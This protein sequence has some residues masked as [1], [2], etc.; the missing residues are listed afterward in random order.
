MPHRSTGRGLLRRDQLA[1]PAGGALLGIPAVRP[2]PNLAENDA[3]SLDDRLTEGLDPNHPQMAALAEDCARFS[4]EHEV[5]L[6]VAGTMD[7]TESVNLVF[8]P[9]EFQPAGDSFDD[10]FHFLG[11]M[12]GRREQQEPWFPRTRTPPCCTSRWARSSPTTPRSTAPASRL[13][14][15][16][17]GRWR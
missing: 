10:R 5:D 2:I 15:V 8:I 4:A 11:P 16:P 6:D 14:E 3:Y 17:P 13:S 12:L 7:V 1:G 9:R